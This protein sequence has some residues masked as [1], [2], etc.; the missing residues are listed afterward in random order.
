MDLTCTICRAPRTASRYAS[1]E[2]ATHELLS[3]FDH[4]V[5]VRL[6]RVV[7]VCQLT[8]CCLVQEEKFHSRL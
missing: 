3:P 1:G 4:G 2:R 7:A 6:E 5:C 8:T